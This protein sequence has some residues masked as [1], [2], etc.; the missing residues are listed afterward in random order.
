MFRARRFL[1]V[2]FVIILCSVAGFAQEIETDKPILQEIPQDEVE[3]E[4]LEQEMEADEPASQE[5]QSED[6]NIESDPNDFALPTPQAISELKT[7]EQIDSN[8]AQPEPAISVNENWKDFLHYLAIGKLDLA[9]GYAKVILESNPDTIKML[10]LA[11]QN[12]NGYKILQRASETSQDKALVQLSKEILALIDLGRYAQ[13]TD[14]Q[15]ILDEIARLQTT[16]RGRMT[17]VKRLEDSGEYAVMYILDAMA[18][19][20]SED[21]FGNLVWALPQIGRDAIRPLAA[22]LQT[23]NV[24]VKVEIIKALGKIG[25]PQALPYLKLVAEKAETEEVR[26]LAVESVSIIDSSAM[27]VSAAQLFYNLAE[28]YYYHTESL[29][30]AK[31]TEFGNIW[32]WDEEKNRLAKQRSPRACFNELMAMRTTEWSLKADPDFGSSI[33]LWIA[34][35]FKAESAGFPMP[36]YFGENHGT[37]SMYATTVGPEYLHQALARAVK[38]KNGFVALGVIEALAKTAGETSLFYRLGPAQ[39]IMDALSFDNKAVKYG[40]AIAIA[41][42]NP[43]RNFAENILVVE[44]L[45]AALMEDSSMVNAE[46]LWN[47]KL[48]E[49]YNFRAAETMY[50]LALTRNP[51][52]EVQAA[53]DAVIKK[54][55]DDRGEMQILAGKILAF[56][57]TPAAQKAIAVAA[58]D[59]K[60]EQTVKLSAFASLTVSAKTNGNM[61]DS[62]IISAIYKLVSSD[63]GDA[64]LRD[65]AAVAYGSLNLPSQKAKD[66]ILDQAKS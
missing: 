34:S 7:V 10:S 35:F 45:S 30:P 56:I 20:G 27:N 43:T 18:K 2:L 58:L 48:A 22:G 19:A 9:K 14:P 41:E 65:A 37:A 44:N 55:S 29:Q 54:I 1:A 21:E 53:Q 31:K 38:D 16:D 51:V 15:I 47:Q 24:K 40:A 4:V 60:N 26:Q 39:P 52:I 63:T 50:K 28:E 13:R 64:S 49:S 8:Q 57:G 12:Q 33:G 62:E 23:N 17:A 59:E 66:L 3:T 5:V 46:G 42:A 25:Y 32:F 11:E 36:Q 61:L 6:A